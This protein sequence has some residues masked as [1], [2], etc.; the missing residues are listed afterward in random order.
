[1][2][3]KMVGGTFRS[4]VVFLSFALFVGLMALSSSAQQAGTILGVVK[5]ASGGTVPQAKVTVTNTDTNDSRTINTGDDGAYSAPGLNPGHYTLKIEKV[6]FKTVNQTGLSLDVAGQLVINPTMEVGSAAQEVTVTGEAPVVG[7]DHQS[8][9]RF[10]QRPT[11]GR[12]A[13]EWP[14]LHGLDAAATGY[15]A[16]DSLRNG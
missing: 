16:D 4:W 13:A 9:G 15:F 8:A 1:M 5:D 7:H 14:K 3:S 12:T 10:G 6:G 11:D 2:K